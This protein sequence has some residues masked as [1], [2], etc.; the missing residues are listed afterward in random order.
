MS[1]QGQDQVA[2]K[3]RV[4]FTFKPNPNT[5]T[6]YPAGVHTVPRAAADAAIAR[7]VAEFVRTPAKR[8]KAAEE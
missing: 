6:V 8:K 5:T 4:P 2:V 1:D 3:F 7:G